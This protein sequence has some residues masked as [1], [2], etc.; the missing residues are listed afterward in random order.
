MPG[1]FFRIPLRIGCG[2]AHHGFRYFCTPLHR[3]LFIFRSLYFCAIGLVSEY[4]GLGRNTPPSASV[5]IHKQVYSLGQK[6][7]QRVGKGD[8]YPP[9]VP[10][11]FRCQPNTTPHRLFTLPVVEQNP[12]GWERKG[13]KRETTGIDFSP[14]IYLSSP[15]PALA[16]LSHA[17]RSFDFLHGAITL[18]RPVCMVA[19]AFLVVL[20]TLISPTFSQ[21]ETVSK[22][23][24]SM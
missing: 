19:T 2:G 7:G 23:F 17:K 22:Q 14:P 15:R 4:S 12:S 21:G 6:D 8:D 24:C 13:E 3:V 20:C 1:P 10:F 16:S 11:F 18:P 9:N 5:C